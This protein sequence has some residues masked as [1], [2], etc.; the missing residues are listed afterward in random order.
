MGDAYYC[1]FDFP[2]VVEPTPAEAAEVTATLT[3]TPA[4]AAEV[5]AIILV[6]LSLFLLHSQ[7]GALAAVYCPADSAYITR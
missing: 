5:T 6:P 7:H 4:K 1:M 3:L 2:P